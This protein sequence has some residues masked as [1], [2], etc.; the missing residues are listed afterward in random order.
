MRQPLPVTRE[1]PNRRF[2]LASTACRMLSPIDC[3]H[4]SPI[5]HP[6]PA[7]LLPNFEFAVEHIGASE[8]F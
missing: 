8:T 4:L 6:T 2:A 7:V 3:F 1:L 5:A